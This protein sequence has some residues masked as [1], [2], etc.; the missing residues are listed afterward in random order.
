MEADMSDEVNP[1]QSPAEI[2]QTSPDSI[3]LTAG[4]P[5]RPPN[6][7]DY[8]SAH[9]R[10]VVAVTVLVLIMV[11]LVLRIGLTAYQLNLVSRAQSGGGVSIDEA[12]LSDRLGAG[13]AVAWLG[14]WTVSGITFIAWS[15]RAYKNLRPLANRRL[16]HS[17]GWA[18]GAWFIPIVNL[19]F[20]YQ[21]HAELW[22]GSDPTPVREQTN[23][24]GRG[25]SL[26]GW[27]WAAYLI[28]NVVNS[29]GNAVVNS[30]TPSTVIDGL[31]MM[32][33]GDCVGLP[34]AAL[35]ISLI[36]RIDRNQ[37]ERYRLLE[38]RPAEPSPALPDPAQWS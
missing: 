32:I 29:I 7:H 14:L 17:P 23:G 26:V 36:R 20:P 24:P 10:A 2:T 3:V 37:T 25:S 19:I 16:E 6:L 12:E 8:R 9:T 13:L 31:T 15:Y 34:A 11:T 33:A 35:A 21:I 5:T 27:W 38:Q 1:Y 18:I 4:G 28:M 22:R 30:A